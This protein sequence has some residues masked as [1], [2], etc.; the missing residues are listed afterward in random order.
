MGLSVSFSFKV[1]RSCLVYICEGPGCAVTVSFS[2]L[3]CLKGNHQL[4]LA[5]II[6]PLPFLMI[7]DPREDGLEKD[8]PFRSDCFKI[9]YSQWIAQLWIPMLMSIHWNHPMVRI[10]QCTHPMGVTK[11]IRS[12]F[13]ACSCSRIIVVAFPLRLP[14]PYPRHFP[15]QGFFPLAILELI[16]YI[17]LSLN[18][19]RSI[20]F[21]SPNCWV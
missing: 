3:L 16:L 1:V 6:S 2:V 20:L 15:R 12:H 17:R 14:S 9:P 21:L 18:S 11:V 13:I 7:S 10:V 19:Q 4:L 5:L 8:S